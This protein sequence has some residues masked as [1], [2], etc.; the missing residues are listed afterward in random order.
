MK[1]IVAAEHYPSQ[2]EEVREFL[3]E[4]GFKIIVFKE[5]TVATI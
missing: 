3:N 1:I 5:R 2:A 4:K